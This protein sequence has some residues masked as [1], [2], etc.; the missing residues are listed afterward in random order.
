M[1]RY[2]AV[3]PR[4]GTRASRRPGGSACSPDASRSRSGA[5][6]ATSNAWSVASATA[7]GMIPRP[8][9]SCADPVPDVRSPQ[10]A[11]LDAA[12]GQLPDQPA[13]VGDDERQHPA[14]PGLATQRA[15]PCVEARAGAGVGR[16]RS[17]PTAA[18]SRRSL[19]GPRASARHR[20][21]GWAAVRPGPSESVTGHPGSV[22][23]P[24]ELVAHVG[25][26][27]RHHGDT[28]ASAADRP[29]QVDDQGALRDRPRHRAT[30]TPS[31][32]PRDARRP[33]SPRRCPA[34]H[35]RGRGASPPASGRR[36]RARCRR[37]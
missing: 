19:P 7:V 24:G 14:G 26:Q 2:A 3:R 30:A 17:P 18:A 4:T 11:V 23:T 36:V 5:A 25:E 32:R 22:V 20:G 13:V 28:V 8:A 15:R 33:G 34:P 12:D 21:A 9:S 10:R 16:A 29:G 31:R 37:W 35:G 27:R 1:C 6:A